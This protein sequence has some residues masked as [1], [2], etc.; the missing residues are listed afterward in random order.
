MTSLLLM[1]LLAQKI[2]FEARPRILLQRSDLNFER[3]T[4]SSN[5]IFV[6]DE[7]NSSVLVFDHKGR[8]TT[9]LGEET[10]N[11]LQLP[12]QV[13]WLPLRQEL[14]V[15]DAANRGFLIWKQNQDGSFAFAR[16]SSTEF[17]LFFEVGHLIQISDIGFAAPVSL[18]KEKYLVGR[19]DLNF[20]PIRYGY[21]I[22]NRQLTTLSPVLRQ[23]FMAKV[24]PSGSD[25]LLTI[26]SLN[27]EVQVFDTNLT[28]LSTISVKP[29]GWK[30]PNMRKLKRVSKNPRELEK[31][32]STYS[33]IIAIYGLADDLFLVGYRNVRA[34]N[35]YTYQ[36]Y[37]A[38]T[39]QPVGQA[40]ETAFWLV[41]N[42][43]TTGYYLDKASSKPELYPIEV[44]KR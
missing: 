14:F 21:E 13:S 37:D 22:M 32:K 34:P 33:E 15:Y 2:D 4:V 26:Q 29:P 16:Q 12:Y 35:L 36:C 8:L 31:L 40:F 5:H 6:R 17:D 7:E 18:V 24:K 42:L 44:V 25:R 10:S 30:D 28:Q 38:N 9:T 43:G 1:V 41:A 11:N 27:P 3:I 23:S 19:F 20:T 39:G